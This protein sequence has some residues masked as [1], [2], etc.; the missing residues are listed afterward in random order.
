MKRL[1]Q[2]GKNKDVE[3][4]AFEDLTL[5]DDNGEVTDGD[6]HE[7]NIPKSGYSSTYSVKGSDFRYNFS[8]NELELLY[9]GR[10][11]ISV[12]INPQEWIDGPN[13]WAETL[14]EDIEDNANI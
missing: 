4:D 14:L 10:K 9:E 12:N 5:V 2:A 11:D 7:F 1:I 6:G 13:Y 3:Y 8:K